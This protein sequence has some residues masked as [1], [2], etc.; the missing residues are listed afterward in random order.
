MLRLARSILLFFCLLNAPVAN[1]DLL[2][3]PSASKV[4]NAELVV[5]RMES[6]GVFD[7]VDQRFRQAYVTVYFK[8]LEG[9]NVVIADADAFAALIPDE[10]VAPHVASFKEATTDLVLMMMHDTHLERLAAIFESDE[11]VTFQ[12]IQNGALAARYDAALEA[13]LSKTVRSQTDEAAIVALQEQRLR[14]AEFDAMMEDTRRNGA[15]GTLK[16]LVWSMGAR[17]GVDA[18]QISNTRVGARNPVTLRAIETN[19]VL[20]FS[21]L[22][23]RNALLRELRQTLNGVAPLAPAR[24]GGITFIRPQST[25]DASN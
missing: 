1:A 9:R 21:S 4:T 3:L 7:R 11:Q 23:Q 14:L 10:I 24:S 25:S 12:N 5:A 17:L 6:S 15:M 18:A 19:G 20:R 8:P 16:S 2:T 13:L 22:V